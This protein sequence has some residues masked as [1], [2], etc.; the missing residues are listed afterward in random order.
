V[1]A[2]SGSY[3]INAEMTRL[4]LGAKQ[5]QV[6]VWSLGEPFGAKLDAVEVP[7][8]YCFPPL[9]AATTGAARL[10]LGLLEH[11]IRELGGSFA[12]GDTDSLAIV[13]TPAGGLVPCPDGDQRLGDRRPAVRALSFEQVDAIVE[14]FRSLSPY[15]TEVIPGSILEVEK[16]NFDEQGR[17]RQ[18]Y[19]Y[20]I[21]AKRYCLY[22]LGEEGY[23][24]I[25]KASEHGLG[26]LL[27]PTDPESD[28]RDWI[29]EAW[30]LLLCRALG[31]PYD[32]PNWLDR[33]ALSKEAITT[34]TKLQPFEDYNRARPPREQVRPGSFFLAAQVVPFGYPVG[35]DPSRF[36]LIAPYEADPRRWRELPWINLYNDADGTEY[37]VAFEGDPSPEVVRA[38]TYRDVIGLYATQPEPKSNGA[39]GKPRGRNTVGLLQRRPV[40]VSTLSRIGKESNSLEERAGGLIGNLEEVLSDYGDQGEGWLELVRPALADLPT[41]VLAERSGLDARTIQRIRAGKTTPHARHQAALALIASDLVAERLE[42]EGI[43]PPADP[44]ARLALY[45]D[46]RERLAPRCKQCG[47]KTAS[48]RSLYCSPT[49]KKRAYRERRRRAA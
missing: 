29:R 14:R 33:P 8:R 12:F 9:A 10:M 4:E 35:V 21:S 11:R 18:L 24:E 2:N 3:G 42:E 1:I 36:R 15:D 5:E 30:R 7:G 28:D 41:S 23:P 37:P 17:R 20:A 26:H 25:V 48:R 40:A 31:L 13:A 34:P 22:V 43:V 38:K 19:A 47:Q 27:N 16:I 6:T 44:V 32:E 46:N 39:D 49:C 45:L